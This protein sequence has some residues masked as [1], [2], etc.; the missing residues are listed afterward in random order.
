MPRGGS[1]KL[2]PLEAMSVD[3]LS[4]LTFTARLAPECSSGERLEY[5]LARAPKGVKIDP[6]K[7]TI[8]WCPAEDQGPGE[9]QITV[10]V[11]VAG[12]PDA[13]ARQT[14]R[15]AVREVLHPPALE[16]IA[17]KMIAPGQKLT[18][19]VLGK[20]VD[21]PSGKL[22]YELGP[23]APPGA[24]IDPAEG[25][26][27]WTAEKVK[28]GEIAQF[29]VRAVKESADGLAAERVVRIQI[30][31]RAPDEETPETIVERWIAE[32]R[33]GGAQVADSDRGPP[34]PDLSG[35]RRLLRIDGQEVAAFGYG[36]PQWARL[37]AQRV[38]PDEL[39][40]LAGDSPAYLFY[41]DRLIVVYVGSNAALLGRLQD[42]LGSAAVVKL[43]GK[44]GP[45]ETAKA[46]PSEQE[47]GEQVI[48]ELHRKNKILAK[49]EYPKI[50]HVFARRFETEHAPVIER[51]LGEASSPVR[52]WLDEHV[53]VKEEFYLAIDPKHDDVARAL[54]LFKELRERFAAKFPAYASLAIAVAVVWDRERGA[55]HG[56][57]IGQ[58]RSVVPEGQL[59]PMENFEYYAESEAVMQG[60][61]RF[62]PW[63][64]LAHVVNHRTPLAD[65]RWAVSNYLAKRAM[66]GKC[67]HDVPYDDGMLAGQAPKLQGRPHT[68]VS[69]KTYGGVCSCQADYAARVAKSLGVPA[70]DA[71]SASVY[72]ESHA[73]VMWVELGPV[74]ATGFAFSLQSYG[75]YRNDKYYVGHLN[76][77]HTGQPTTDRELELRLHTLGMDPIAKRQAD[78]VMRSYRMLREKTAMDT[79]G[80]LLFLNRVIGFCPGNEEAWRSLA[81]LSREGQI[82]KTNSKPMRAAMDRLFLTFAN[83][84]DFTR[85]VFDD[86]VAFEDRVQQRVALSARLAAMYEQAGRPDLSC[87]ARLQHAQ[88]LVTE[89]RYK[90]AVDSL[91]AAIL[92]FPE[93]GRYV[94]KMLDKMEQLCD[95]HVPE[96]KDLLPRFYQQILPRIPRMRGDR[97]SPYCM[98]MYQRAIDRFRKAGLESPARQYESELALLKARE[99]RAK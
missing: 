21:L 89:K 26:V 13:A 3:E 38:A 93:E 54:G 32:L 52:K 34:H 65:R 97:P 6:S 86:M 43:P 22:R 74:T 79:A 81:H 5:S 62:L 14:Y 28:P 44:P 75:R 37:E 59:G 29:T 80:Q 53:D 88:Y 19:Q 17:D 66:I 57:P 8:T 61:T 55:I 70:F 40:K 35:T 50:R 85:V 45:V 91:A 18:F 58:H 92:L 95:Q 90:D 12:D 94:P 67:Y 30:A 24:T 87:E 11:A 46:E 48:L 60:R 27:E 78:L 71:G 4:T 72:G 25:R 9:Y 42:R 73:W 49:A 16:E 63:E 99:A 39:G 33:S 36:A 76:D 56:S 64:F 98:S 47:K 77:P 20:D 2:Q 69:Q 7:G 51:V 23:D 84:P 15:V 31:E 82:T 96:A 10:R 83:L 1:L 41:K 68:L